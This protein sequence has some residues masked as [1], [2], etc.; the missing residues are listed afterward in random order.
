MWHEANFCYAN[1]A[2]M[3]QIGGGIEKT[4]H[5]LLYFK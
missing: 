2:G 5:F 3:N 1:E 4:E